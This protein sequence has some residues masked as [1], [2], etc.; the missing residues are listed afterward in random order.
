MQQA[1]AHLLQIA[2]LL[3]PTQPGEPGI[4][5]RQRVEAHLAEVGQAVEEGSIPP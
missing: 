2:H 5:V 1:H 3:E 4:E